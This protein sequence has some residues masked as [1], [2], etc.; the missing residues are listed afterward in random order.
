MQNPGAVNRAPMTEREKLISRYGDPFID[1]VS[2]EVKH[3]TLYRPDKDITDAIPCVRKVYCNK[4]F[5]D[6]LNRVFRALIAKGFAGEIKTFGGCYNVRYIRGYEAQKI[7]SI[8][9][10]AMAIDFNTAENPLGGPVRFTQPFLQVWR[11]EGFVCGAD[12]RRKD[13][14]HFQYTTII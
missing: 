7:P 6:P 4:D 10:Y 14:M 8:H 13:A 11:D 2:F 9:A 5:V 12:F 3:M 1:R